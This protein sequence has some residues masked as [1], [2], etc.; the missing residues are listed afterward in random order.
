MS[1]SERT[2]F[3]MAQSDFSNN[4]PNSQVAIGEL[5]GLDA[6]RRIADAGGKFCRV[7]A[8]NAPG[9]SPGKRA[10]G[11]GWQ[12]APYTFEEIQPHIKSGGN[13]GLICGA[14]SAGL[15]LLDA[16]WN[17][18]GFCDHFPILAKAPRIAREGSDR[19]KILIRVK[20][21]PPGGRKFY[22]SEDHPTYDPSK[23]HQSPYF[24]YLGTGNQGVIPPST[25]PETRGPYCLVNPGQPIPEMTPDQISAICLLWTGEGLELARVEPQPRPA[26][27]REFTGEGDQ[28]KAKVL[29]AWPSPLNVFKNFGW[30]QETDLEKGG[31]ELR[32]KHHGGLFVNLEKDI[33]N[34]VGQPGL[35]GDVFNA[36]VYCKT[37]G[38]RWETPEGREFYELLCEMARAAHI[39]IP[40][41]VSTNG[42]G[43]HVEEDPLAAVNVDDLPQPNEPPED[44]E[45][46]G[47]EE[48]DPRRRSTLGAR[49][50][51]ETAEAIEARARAIPCPD[52]ALMREITDCLV[53]PKIPVKI[54]RQ[55][56]GARLLRWL[57]D[58]GEFIKSETDE[59]FY[60]YRPERRLYNLAS[61]H[62]R[63]WL[64]SLT[65]A[66]PAGSDFAYFQ[67]DCE[68]AAL[69]ARRRQVLRVAAW[70][71]VNKVLRVSRFDG[72]VYRLD[73]SDSIGEEGNGE[74]VL[75]DD[76]PY[77]QPYQPDYSN[78]QAFEQMAG[79]YFDCGDPQNEKEYKSLM[80]RYQ[81]A[82]IVWELSTFFPELCPTRP[83]LVIHGEKGSGKSMT[84]RRFGRCLYGPSYELSG[85]PD[86]QDG[87]TASAAAAHVLAIDNLDEFHGWMRDKIARLTTG[88]IDEYRKLYTSNEV[89]RVNYRCW[90]AFTSRTPDTLRR[91]DLADRLILLPVKRIPEAELKAERVFLDAAEA[92][93]NLWWGSNL[94][95]LN[96]IVRAI[97]E[98]KLQTKARLRMADWE[99]FG[100]LVAGLNGTREIW[101]A[102]I[103]DLKAAQ[104]NFLLEGDPIAESLVLWLEKNPLRHGESIRTRDLYP[105]LEA[106]LYPGRKAP[107]EWPDS[108]RKFG[109]RLQMI[110]EALKNVLD[111]EWTIDNRTGASYRFW[112][113][114]QRE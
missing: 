42:N 17:F 63:A 108:L 114:G 19:G 82:L 69:L 57:T 77:W 39:E 85:V 38:R 80:T 81:L 94:M 74:N 33:W 70:D 97:R 72:T 30:V 62:W 102:F 20:G 89:G 13:V 49:I 112:P 25:H 11:E 88:G 66:N 36:W 111:V 59:L 109:R 98:G 31:T 54:K 93:R 12:N 91:D 60:L 92:N 105:D 48:P 90:L 34:V 53:E 96:L 27:R 18:S 44:W 15:V 55:T 75:F 2:V 104:T 16:D 71:K 14:H 21:E 51:Q 10:L 28:L 32:I 35:G 56:A 103:D 99:S 1:Q 78:P 23:T 110:R 50:T 67:A 41:R 37:E 101:D 9:N 95:I 84:L 107:K 40:Q 64:Y 100:R 76:S 83:A 86:K 46:A 3:I 4:P 24:E 45:P 29:E 65:G 6:L 47:G 7:A 8:W 58:Q 52:L 68:T 106:L 61:N 73:G 26:R 43:H 87:F 5:V 79:A 113:K 22:P